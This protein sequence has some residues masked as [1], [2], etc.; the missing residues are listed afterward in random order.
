MLR[1]WFALSVV[2]TLLVRSCAQRTASTDLAPPDVPSA[3]DTGLSERIER[4][5]S[6][7]IG[8]TD[9][10]RILSDQGMSL[11]AR[12]RHHHVPGVSIAV[13]NNARIVQLNVTEHTRCPRRPGLPFRISSGN[14]QSC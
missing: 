7:L 11:H 3:G 13:I 2:L 12:M 4:V 9:E 1:G 10:G 14:P 6:G 8:L 5:E